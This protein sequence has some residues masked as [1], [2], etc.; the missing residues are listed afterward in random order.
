M[1]QLKPPGELC[2]EGNLAENWRKWIQSFELFFIASEI[3]EKSEKVLC[4]T[5]LHIAGEEALLYSTPSTLPRM[6]TNTK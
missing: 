4:A 2:L 1:E 6:G 3:S 5:F